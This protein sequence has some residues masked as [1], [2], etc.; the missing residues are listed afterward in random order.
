M[1][2]MRYAEAVVEALRNALTEDDSTQL[3][4]QY[5]LGVTPDG[6][7]LE[8]IQRE[9]ATRITYPPIAELGTVGMAIGAAMAGVRPIVDIGTASFIFQAFPQIVNEAANVHY[10][11][12]GQTA[13]PMVF[14]FLHGIRGGG[15]AQHSHSPQAMLWNTPGIEIIA[16]AT[17]ADVVGLM[18]T[19]VSSNNPTAWVSHV[20]LFDQVGD[21]PEGPDFAVPF[22]V[23]YVPRVGSDVSVVATSLMVRRAL[24]A[25]EIVADRGIEAEVIDL[26]TIVPLDEAAIL[27]SVAKTGRLVVVDECHRRCGVAAEIAAMVAEQAFSELVRPIRRVVTAD[28]PVPA[29]P[30]LEQAIEPTEAKIVEAILEI[31]D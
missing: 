26:R 28:I 11:S 17:P 31:G 3:I 15:A 29:S 18:R 13:V 21:V 10:M 22:G 14:H 1:K 25:A 12:G 19:A 2:Q 5:F 9:F 24:A 27:S 4:G 8:P 30:R 7:L 23:A 16:P 20:K 6:P